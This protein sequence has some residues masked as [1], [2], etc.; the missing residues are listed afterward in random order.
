M[1][2]TTANSKSGLVLFFFFL[3]WLRSGGRGRQCSCSVLKKEKEKKRKSAQCKRVRIFFSLIPLLRILFNPFT[4]YSIRCY[5]LLLCLSSISIS[6]S[7]NKRTGK[8]ATIS[9][10][11]SPALT[12]RRPFKGK[13]FWQVPTQDFSKEF[14]R[15]NYFFSLC[16]L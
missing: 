4:P 12:A 1:M 8:T 11:G 14:F 9:P 2:I 15:S 3:F 5:V 6:I 16:S 7:P 10:S 13:H